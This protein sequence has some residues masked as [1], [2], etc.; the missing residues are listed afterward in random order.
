[1]WPDAYCEMVLEFD[2]RILNFP[3]LGRKGTCDIEVRASF[4][5]HSYLSTNAQVPLKKISTWPV[6]PKPSLY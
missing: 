6:S 3:L 5:I 4:F 2:F 1:M